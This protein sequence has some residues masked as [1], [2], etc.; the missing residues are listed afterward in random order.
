[1][2]IK[3]L[4]FILFN[5]LSLLAQN[6][7]SII[8]I[9][10]E[11]HTNY[12]DFYSCCAYTYV[13]NGSESDGEIFQIKN[14]VEKTLLDN[15]G[16]SFF[17][18]VKFEFVEISDT[19]S[20]KSLNYYPKCD[21]AKCKMKYFFHYAFYPDDRISYKFS[22]GVNE[23]GSIKLPNDFPD[24]ATK[25][26]DTTLKIDRVVSIANK[27][28][29]KLIPYEIRFAY[30]PKEKIF[31]WL[32]YE[33]DKGEKRKRDRSADA[34]GDMTIV[35]SVRIDANDAG[36]AKKIKVKIRHICGGSL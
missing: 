26:I 4:I 15:S 21:P 33:E 7:D 19:D 13:F 34:I 30:S 18:R 8:L 17:S 12:K 10:E 6:R 31:L 27:T 9:G 29:N 16:E 3:S 1:M 35:R 36:R 2:K 25:S 5:A 22:I 23:Q 28:D 14:A 11:N 24:K 32:V 20:I